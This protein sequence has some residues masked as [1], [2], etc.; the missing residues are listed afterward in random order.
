VVAVELKPERLRRRLDPSTLGF[1]STADVEPLSGTVGQPRALEAITFG[2]RVST[3]G[4][5]L[6]VAGA[7]GS[8]RTSTIL[9]YLAEEAGGRP[10]PDDWVYVHNFARP[11]R[12]TAIRLP[13]GRGVE[14]AGD[15]DEFVL[16]AKSALA[17]AFESES[18]GARERELV[19][20]L[21]RR[22]EE[23][24]QELKSFA[25]ERNFALEIAPV[26]VVTAAIVDGKPL[27]PERA[28]SL[29]ELQRHM[30]DRAQAE[31]EEQTMRFARE[32]H[33]LGKDAAGRMRALEREVASFAL[34]SVF[35][36]LRDRYAEFAS[37]VDYLRAVE[38]DV[39]AHVAEFRGA[40]E[41]QELPSPM[42][43][44]E[45]ARFKVNVL[46]DNG[47]LTG[48]PVVVERSP[49]YRNLIGRIAYRPTLGAMVTDFREVKAGALHRSNGG[50]LVLD[51]LD[52]LGHPFAW[53]ALKRALRTGEVQ[54]E[55][56]TE[57]Y[58][59]VPT[60]TLRPDPVPLD[61][62]VVLVGS[63]QA[64]S[65]LYALDE[66]FRELFRVKADFAPD[67][68]WNRSSHRAYA[69]FVSRW[70]RDNG[71]LPVDAGGVA[72][73]IEHGARLTENQ[74]K[75][76]TR[77]IEIADVAAEA[78]YIAGEA[79]RAVVE[80]A[81][82]AAAVERRRY[83][84]SL[85][86]ERIRE[87]IDEGTLVIETEGERVGVVNGLSVHDLGDYS[88]GRP[89]RVSARVSVGR[90]SVA[91]IDR[92]IELSGPIHSKGFLTLTG[93]LAGA[94]A[95]EYPLA[96]QATITFEQ[97]Y[98]EVE[99]DSASSAELFALL[100]ALSG[101]PLR[102]DVA[103][104]GSVDQQGRLQAVGGINEKIEGFHATCAARGLTGS[105]GVLI[106]A[107]NASNLM[108]DEAVVEAVRAGAFHVWTARTVDEGVALLTGARAGRRRGDGT[109]PP[110][111]VHGLVEERLRAY[112]TAAASFGDSKNG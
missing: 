86:E 17:A 73:L 90:G 102:Q 11:D 53:D 60:P 2:L 101:L 43:G 66:D 81:D 47:T 12:P 89:S 56:L 26:G 57:E 33:Q 99:G 72:R 27:T 78:S 75:L 62:K 36:E 7:P 13:A 63:R 68:G 40:G 91:S 54:I 21:N 103:V 22:R 74:R 3:A 50:F 96:L 1:A 93:Y 112:A 4:H 28:A 48:A 6:F 32:M 105:Q 14:F 16:A 95:Q 25:A 64:Y 84:S 51:V 35:R 10:V 41:S 100:S 19:S 71:L 44:D 97:S 18:Y 94:Y 34:S 52:V 5:N 31:I 8:G 98:T 80:A 42:R 9:D 39:L 20:E 49:Q 87:L 83:R 58:S 104:T 69:A 67:M 24:A 85:V 109:F 79:G 29:D 30:I 65:I 70:A 55:N 110:G 82:V 111:S 61:V 92:E 45:F 59:S 38:E 77:L 108:L 76:S 37:V 15:M 88:F 107:A 46:V 106:P 23:L